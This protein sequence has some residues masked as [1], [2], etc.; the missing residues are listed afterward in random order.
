MKNTNQYSLSAA[1]SSLQSFTKLG[2][3]VGWLADWLV[4]EQ[5]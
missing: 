1:L 3:L 2:W 5:K 4:S